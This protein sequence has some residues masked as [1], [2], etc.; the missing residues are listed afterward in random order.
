MKILSILYLEDNKLDLELVKSKLEDAGI[1]FKMT[2]VETQADFEAALTSEQ[3]EIILSD[4]A[5]PS[6][7]GP[8]ALAL[9]RKI[10]PGVPVIMV[11]GTI[12]EEI[13]VDTLKRGATDY[14][15]K[16]RM[17]RLIPSIKRALK[18]NEESKRRK[19]AEKALQQ[20]QEK[21][22]KYLDI[23]E[24]MIV[25]F[26][27][28]G[29]I[30]LV[31][32]KGASILGYHTD[33]L[34]GKNWFD[35]F[36]PKREG[37]SGKKSYF[38]S[39]KGK[40][41]ILDHFEETIV[42]SS[43]EERIIDW[44]S[45]P[46]L[47]EEK[48][49]IGILGSGEDITERK[50]IEKSMILMSDTQS[51]ITN[52]DNLTDI[53]QL[54]GKKIRE[55]IGEGYVITSLYD[56]QIE[57][58]RVVGINGF[59]DLYENLTRKLKINPFK[60]VYYLKDM[61]AN[62]LRAYRS[63][64][65]EKFEGDLYNLLTGKVPKQICNIAEKEF[66]FTGIYVIGF[67]WHDLDFGG[68]TIFPK[69]DITQYKPMIETIMNQASTTIKRIKSEEDLRISEQKLRISLDGTI[70]TIAA[71]VE[72][73]DPYTAGHQTRVADLAAVIASEMHLSN[74]K[75]EGIKMAGIIHDLGKI[76]TP[77]EILSKP[78]KLSELEFQII[79]TH[80]QVG[81]D[82]LK[83]IEFPWP[84][85][86]MVLQHHEKM[87]G[88]GYPRGLKGDEIMLEA[89]ILTVSDIVEAMSSHRPYRP[90]HGIDKALKQIKK[91]KGTLLD[92]KVV[93]ACL[94][95]FEHG[96]KLPEG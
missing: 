48:Q 91:D 79:Q 38:E 12:G 34:I 33:E 64:E 55:L 87:D 29:D 58:M 80:P 67:I 22:Q 40:N 11:S 89:R 73:R 78:G 71:T 26:N 75:I 23:A 84:I 42:T 66:N 93:D 21:A 14:V 50:R 43:G 96:Y 63:G 61:S 74:E 9:A 70:H 77:A 51:Q 90:A 56:E 2:H 16:Q 46:L 68:V 47:D 36:L 7:D 39:I 19:H 92:P 82:L 5:L 28:K 8:S 32:Q 10:C 76:N 3:F 88:S 1:D 44:H 85:A 62:H 31:N 60:T 83:E 17:A 41:K 94:K 15:I 27:K 57:A 18:E 69:R 81:F 65:L 54:I 45:T 37:E 59:G 4:Y 52:Q 72:A 30:T 13:A 95:V 53:Y 25:A 6:F 86:G 35:N 24:V 20:E 49:T